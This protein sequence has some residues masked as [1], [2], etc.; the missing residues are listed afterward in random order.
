MISCDECANWAPYEDGDC[1][2]CRYSNKVTGPDDTCEDAVPIVW[3][4]KQND[5]TDKI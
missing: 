4:S 2:K 1:G 5:K 3:K